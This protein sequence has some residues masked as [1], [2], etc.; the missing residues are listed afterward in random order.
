MAYTIAGYLYS[1][2]R[3]GSD[4]PAMDVC[5]VEVTKPLVARNDTS[6]PQIIQVSG[7]TDLDQNTVQ[8]R[9]ASLDAAGSGITEHATCT[10]KYS[11]PDAWLSEWAQIAYLVRARIDAL[12]SAVNTGSAV[13]LTRGLVYK[14]F[15]A[16]VEYGDAYKGLE[17]VI[18]DNTALE[19]TAKVRF[20]SSER[21]GNFFCSPYWIDSLG[22]LSGFVANG[23]DTTDSKKF[24]Y[25]SHGWKYL[26][27]AKELSNTAN[28]QTYVKM[29]QVGDTNMVAGDVYVFDGDTIVG[30]MGGLRFQRVPRPVLDILVPPDRSRK[31]VSQGA[32]KNVPTKPQSETARKPVTVANQTKTTQ[33]PLPQAAPPQQAKN[34]TKSVPGSL[35][36]K[37]LNIIAQEAE[38]ELSEIQ[39]ECAFSDLGVD[40]LLSLSVAGKFR[41][42]LDLD[43]PGSFFVDYPTVKS[44]KAFLRQAEGK[45][46]TASQSDPHQY[47]PQ[48]MIPPSTAADSSSDDEEPVTPATP[49]DDDNILSIIQATI[50][51]QMELAVEE[52]SGS[53]DLGELGVD[54]LMQIS[55]LGSLRETLD[56]PLPSSFL[57]DYPSMDAIEKYFKRQQSTKSIQ[58]QSASLPSFSSPAPNA[59][60][61]VSTLLQG[62]RKTATKTLFIFPDGSGS[63]S[64]YA[65]IPDIA[66]DVCVYG[67]DCPFMKTPQDYTCGIE[68]VSTM[69]L[70]EVRRR[71]STGPYYLSGWSAGGI[72]AYEV[73]LQLQAMGERVER[74]ILLDSPCPIRLPALPSRL[75]E[76]FGEIGLFGSGG[77]VPKWLLPHFEA[78]IRNLTAY[79]P[80]PMDRRVAPKTFAIWAE[81]G[82]CKNP[83]DPRPVSTA[84]DPKSMKWLLE[85]RT[86]FGDNGWA[87]LLGLENIKTARVG[88]NHFSLMKEPVVGS[89][90]TNYHING[91]ADT[92]CTG[93]PIG[94]T[95]QT[96]LRLVIKVASE[97][98]D[99]LA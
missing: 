21:D 94:S 26:R 34:Q 91:S 60:P 90:Q 15:S 46:S 48:E 99:H 93:P 36:V 32:A 31:T 92:D 33:R 98:V 23:S 54:S 57:I 65:S 88:A 97:R 5:Q 4:R 38:I 58:P 22:H 71:Q 53:A 89:S 18:L 50:A 8:L 27:F 41:E 63:A 9:Y 78:S 51:E 55:I 30:V 12:K 49:A 14:L 95:N 28:Y 81:D 79:K 17:E 83:E 70:Q 62:N 82:V 25:I 77:K 7:N 43:I 68:A 20:Q 69:Y 1:Q 76:F 47:E 87:P 35:T 37:A 19:A 45:S 6:Q 13:K 10:V 64:S 84:D 73:A 72:V 29:Q 61:A 80:K 75:H 96:G 24:V 39:D 66:P 2:L 59:P 56:I 42:E 16:I 85:N 3:P 52:I 74:L 40:S 67:L 11:D 86:D 44:L